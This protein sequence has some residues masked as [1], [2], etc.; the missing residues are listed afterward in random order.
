[1]RGSAVARPSQAGSQVALA[2]MS[3]RT[4]SSRTVAGCIRRRWQPDVRATNGLQVP[5]LVTSRPIERIVF[6]E[7]S[8]FTAAGSIFT[9]PDPGRTSK[10]EAKREY[11]YEWL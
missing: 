8:T 10:L 3:V 9:H 4:D 7:L 5:K 11:C 1:M 2:R 6:P